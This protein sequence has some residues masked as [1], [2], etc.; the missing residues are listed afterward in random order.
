MTRTFRFLVLA[1][2]AL[3]Q[4]GFG[5]G[6]AAAQEIL[7][8]QNT[9]RS[10]HCAPPFVWSNALA[11][12][13]QAWANACH[14]DSS[15]NFCHQSDT[16]NCPGATGNTDGENL[17][18]GPGLTAADAVHLWYGENGHYNYSAPNFSNPTND[19]NKEVLHFTQMVWKGSTQL[20][21]AVA[22]C[23]GQNLW[24]CEYS[25]Q[26]NI[27]TPAP[28][29]QFV[30]NVL[31]AT[32]SATGPQT[33]KW[34]AFASN[35]DNS[36]ISH[37]IFVSISLVGQFARIHCGE[38]H[39]DCGIFWMGHN[40]CVAYA[41]GQFGGGRRYGAG[42]GATDAEAKRRALRAC[43]PEVGRPT[44]PCTIGGSWCQ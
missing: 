10:L 6:S 29:G 2:L 13:A 38:K 21:C 17:A 36:R 1:L 43:Q 25:P 19:P 23:S 3:A 40:R 31:P 41:Q 42:G 27:I 35:Q 33:V 30:Q 37:V 4:A 28:F 39:F 12:K 5:A 44:P 8:L 16:Q 32:C 24:V 20:G 18:W 34:S 15:G 26:G 7:T 11:T 14:K 22:N 9:E